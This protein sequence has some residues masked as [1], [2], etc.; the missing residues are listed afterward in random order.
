MVKKNWDYRFGKFQSCVLSWSSKFLPSLKARVEVLNIFALSRVYYLASILPISKSMARKFDTVLG[1][2]IWGAGWLLRVA[3]DEVKLKPEKGGLNLCCVL[4]MSNSLLISQFLRL[5]KSS[6]DRSVAHVSYW[7]GD[8]LSDLLPGIENG[9]HPSNVPD[10]YATIESSIVFGR[11]NDVIMQGTWK[12]VTNKMLY[13]DATK[14]LPVPKVEYEAGTSFRRVWMLLNS[15][16]L[17]SNT[18]DVPYLLIHNKLPVQERLYRV[19]IKSDPY[20]DVC[21]GSQI[22]DTEH[23][24]CSCSKVVDAW[25][26]LHQKLISMIGVS[27]SNENIIKLQFPSSD[28]DTELV[29]LICNYTTKVWTDIF[30]SKELHI[31]KDELFGFLRFKYKEDQQGSRLPMRRILDI[32]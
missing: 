26:W 15:P 29:W 19:G 2:F 13:I 7:I 16:I 22:A 10:Y 6:D 28:Y 31:K 5:L 12:L 3:L 21:P 1:K 30:A 11:I 14:T 32:F 27:I 8:T 25:S 20:C 9:P 17:S 24:F 4:R 18:K 23:F